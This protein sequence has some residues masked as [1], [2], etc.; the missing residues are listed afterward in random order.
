MGGMTAL[1]KDHGDRADIFDDPEAVL[2][3]AKRSFAKARRRAVEENDRLGIT[4]VGSEDGKI[5]RKPPAVKPP[6]P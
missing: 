1:S 3:L 2:E 4:S 6:T 5:V